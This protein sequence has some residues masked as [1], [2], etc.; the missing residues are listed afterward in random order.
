MVGTRKIPLEAFEEYISQGMGRSY[1][2]IARKYSVTK[3]AQPGRIP[4]LN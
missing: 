3:K 2:A 4:G 1:N